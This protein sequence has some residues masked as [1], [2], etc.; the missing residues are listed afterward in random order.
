VTALLDAA[1]AHGVAP[2]AARNLRN[3]AADGDAANVVADHRNAE[4]ILQRACDEVDRRVVLL[5]GRNLL[6]AHHAGRISA[7]FEH[8]ALPACIVKGPVFA[9][10]LYPTPTDRSFTDIDILVDPAFQAASAEI[11][12]D[13]GFTPAPEADEAP[14]DQSERKWLFRENPI[15]MVELQT[16]LV[17]SPNLRTGIHLDYSELIAAGA[18]DSED[19]TALLMLAAVHGAAGHQFER[20]QLTVDILLAARGMAGQIDMRRLDHMARKTGA[21]AALQSALDLTARLY[22]EPA[23]RDIANALSPLPWRRLRGSLVTPAVALRAQSRTAPW[24]SWRRRALRDM[25]RRMGMRRVA[26]AAT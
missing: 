25:I 18:G 5:A 15:V 26:E 2:A 24:D 6:L 1:A 22:G 17:H 3:L 7:A 16:N 23:A 14:R 20:L 4:Q 8:A 21:L 12:T 13:L 19:A 11:L 10:R 9:R